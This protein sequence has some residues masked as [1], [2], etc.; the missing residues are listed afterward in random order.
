MSDCIGTG[1]KADALLLQ[2]TKL[3]AER[4]ALQAR[5]AELEPYVSGARC[6]HCDHLRLENGALQADLAAAINQWKAD[7]AERDDA[8]RTAQDNAAEAERLQK[9]RDYVL[10]I[11][12]V[13]DNKIDK[14]LS[15]LQIARSTIYSLDSGEIYDD[16]LALID[17]A[18][19]DYGLPP[20]DPALLE[21]IRLRAERDALRH[22]IDRHVAI[23]AEQAQEIDRLRE[24]RDQ[25]YSDYRM[26][27]DKETKA[28]TVERDA[29]AAENLTLRNAAV[30]AAERS[31]ALRAL[32]REANLWVRAFDGDD[33]DSCLC[34]R[35]S[36]ALKVNL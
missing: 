27:C 17:A 5:V 33:S 6:P 36:L 15:A 22:D 18:L 19:A 35:I 23:A 32:L 29:L 16:E 7:I 3:R 26:K 9:V 20:K 2:I 12:N 14:L 28:V 11:I 4:D 1:C 34:N 21:L 31:D 13:Q 8:I 10:E 25:F 24:E 30:T